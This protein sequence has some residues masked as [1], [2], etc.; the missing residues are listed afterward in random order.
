MSSVDPKIH[1]PECALQSQKVASASKNN[2]QTTKKIILPFHVVQQSNQV[3]K[4]VPWLVI[5]LRSVNRKMIQETPQ[6]TR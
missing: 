6:E 2:S 4:L 5:D 3:V 1:L